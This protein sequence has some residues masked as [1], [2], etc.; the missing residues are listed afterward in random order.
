M[1]RACTHAYI[2]TDAGQLPQPDAICQAEAVSPAPGG[3]VPQF[4]AQ[5][6]QL[7]QIRLQQLRI[8]TDSLIFIL[9]IC[10]AGFF[11]GLPSCQF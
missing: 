10:M 5:R 8:L 6:G 9:V 2:I 3:R 4:R 1:M 11:Q 7:R